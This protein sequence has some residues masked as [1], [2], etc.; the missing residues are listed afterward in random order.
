MLTSVAELPYGRIEN[1]NQWIKCY[2]YTKGGKQF[3]K[4]QRRIDGFDV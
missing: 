4:P 1:L 3:V 2:L